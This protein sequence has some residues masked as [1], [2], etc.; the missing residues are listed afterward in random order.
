[1]KDE[2]NTLKLKEST[3][4]QQAMLQSQGLLAQEQLDRSQPLGYH[5]YLAKRMQTGAITAKVGMKSKFMNY[6][7]LQQEP[8]D[9]LAMP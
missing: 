1:M 9:K 4:L 6:E 7:K 2:L 8:K 3:T 5:D